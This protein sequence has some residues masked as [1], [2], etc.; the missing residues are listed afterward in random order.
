[1]L[2]L[3][4][5][6]P[7]NA[8]GLRNQNFELLCGF[9]LHVNLFSIERPRSSSPGGI[10][11]PWTIRATTINLPT[12]YYPTDSVVEIS[13]HPFRHTG[14]VELEL[15][16]PE[17]GLA[18]PSFPEADEEK[19][20]KIRCQRCKDHILISEEGDDRWRWNTAETI[21]QAQQFHQDPTVRLLVDPPSSDSASV[22]ASVDSSH[23]CV[24]NG[25]C[26]TTH[27]P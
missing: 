18:I 23:T 12:G 3:F 27:H 26:H 17:C 6:H 9:R 8:H 19:D 1:M 5:E 21:R 20:Q 25:S 2:G 14:S 11:G 13:Y 24:P 22:E 10:N 4:D 7:A 16:C 15:S